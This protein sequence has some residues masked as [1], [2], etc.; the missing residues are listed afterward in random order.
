MWRKVN[1]PFSGSARNYPRHI[2]PTKG[3]ASRISMIATTKGYLD[4]LHFR[5]GGNMG[6]NELSF[7]ILLKIKL[8]QRGAASAEWS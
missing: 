8:P 2:C 6:R 3:D 4:R 7:T 5:Y 1:P